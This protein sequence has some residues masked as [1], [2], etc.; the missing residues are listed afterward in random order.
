MSRKARNTNVSVSG[1][2][3][4]DKQ[5][6][7]IYSFVVKSRNIGKLSYVLG[8]LGPDH[9]ESPAV[10]QSQLRNPTVESVGYL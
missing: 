3:S 9:P 7:Q 5:Q 4:T 10:G 2:S 6:Q 8:G 1:L